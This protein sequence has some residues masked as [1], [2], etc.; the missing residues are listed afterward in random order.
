M[1]MV[2]VNIRVFI[3]GIFAARNL[4]SHRLLSLSF[5]QMLAS[6]NLEMHLSFCLFVFAAS[7]L[8]L[9]MNV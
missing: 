9:L 8:F 6:D 3:R 4:I 7:V 5:K 2:S 1:Y